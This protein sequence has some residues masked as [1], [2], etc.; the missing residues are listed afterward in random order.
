MILRSLKT[1][2]SERVTLILE[3]GEE[4]V[5]TLGVVTE[6]RLYA[7]KDL[8]ET[9]LK[10]LRDKTVVAAAREHALLL[11]S[12]RP[13][14]QKE[15]R[16]KLIRKGESAEAAD[17]AIAWLAEHGYLDDAG[18]AATV[19]RHY[20]QK[21]YGVQRV[22]AEL[23]R[24]GVPRELWDEALGEMAEPDNQI[25]RF[26]RSRLQNPEDRKE[27]QKLSAALLRRGYSWEDIRAAF[28][29]LGGTD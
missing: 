12:H 28:Q 15:L 10:Q 11:F 1:G 8:D 13:H 19:V 7:G 18:Y 21:G 23:S 25:E 20:S 29:R 17:A 27:V 4:I 2:G 3:D 22:R 14:S 16:D 5:S 6:L 9:E 24:R 26:L